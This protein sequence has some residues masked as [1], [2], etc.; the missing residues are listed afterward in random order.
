MRLLI[1]DFLDSYTY[2]IPAF[3]QEVLLDF[4]PISFDVRSFQDLSP[5]D[6]TTVTSTYDGAILSAGPGT[7]ENDSDLGLFTPALISHR[8][9]IPIYGICFGFQAICK[10]FGGRIFQLPT[11]H[12]G[13]ISEILDINH[14]PLGRRATRYHSLDVHL[15]RHTLNFLEIQGIARNIRD[16]SF[17]VMEVRHRF[18]PFWGV[19]YHPESIY[20]EACHVMAYGFFEAV[21]HRAKRGFARSMNAKRYHTAPRIL[22]KMCNGDSDHRSARDVLWV[23]IDRECDLLQLVET[24]DG[25]DFTLLDSGGKG[26]W[27]IFTDVSTAKTFQYSLKTTEYSFG[28]RKDPIACWQRGKKSLEGIWTWL[29]DFSA[30]ERFSNGPADVPFWGGFCGYFSYEVGLAQLGIRPDS[31][32]DGGQRGTGYLGPDMHLLWSTET[33]LYHRQTKSTYI[34]SLTRNASWMESVYTR[35]HSKSIP[36]LNRNH[37]QPFTLTHQVVEPDEHDYL[38]KIRDCQKQ[39]RAGNSYELCLTAPTRIYDSC[40]PVRPV[41]TKPIVNGAVNTTNS[42]PLTDMFRDLRFKSPEAF[43]SLLRLGGTE[44]LSASPEMFLT[45]DAST[46]TAT[47]K[48][49]KGTLSKK[50]PDGRV[51]SHAEAEEALQTPK[52]V[53]ENLMIVDL[54]R[55]DLAKVADSV[56]CPLL[57]HVQEIETMYQLVSTIEASTRPDV[58]AWDLLRSCLPP[59]SMTG[60]PKRRSCEILREIEGHEPRG[61]YSGVV[62]YVDVRGNCQTSVSIRNAVRHAGEEFWRVGAGG[63]ITC[64]SDP[65][66][67]WRERQLKA[68][69]V[70]R[71]FLPSFEILETVVWRPEEGLVCWHEHVDRLRRSIEYFRFKTPLLSCAEDMTRSSERPNGRVLSRDSAFAEALSSWTTAQL[72]PATRA[73]HLRLSLTVN[74]PGALSLKQT[75]I[76]DPKQ[77]SNP[78]ILVRLDPRSTNTSTLDPFIMHKTTHREHYDSAR[79]RAGVQLPDEVLLFRPAEARTADDPEPHEAGRDDDILTE[80]SYTNVAVRSGDAGGG[81]VTPRDS[82]LAGIERARLLRIGEVV[83]GDV[84]RRDVGPGARIRL[85]NS[86]RGCFEGVVG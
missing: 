56:R 28:S 13:V 61:L 18:L 45:F 78:P 49:I 6:I 64:L 77:P 82:C 86:V 73:Q 23:R 41:A 68:N 19:Q 16:D 84:R 62:G 40:T 15:D 14:Q 12:H 54:I 66:D 30:A 21:L 26:E 74:A 58:T 8:P 85:F 5:A 57:M 33:V 72:D 60:A 55:N 1:V 83:D 52:V 80:G 7:V 67:E 32:S 81:W 44:L 29:K 3:L 76:A 22:K 69:S 11:P 25:L 31:Q 65:V 71:T 47:M 48:P 9:A 39:I 34:L 36:G 59:G 38:Q 70:L 50:S 75:P 79:L 2:S 46:R 43:M 4:I 37:G 63:A 24:N 20:S 35:L 42:V 27:D 10:A 53:A 17:S 51:I